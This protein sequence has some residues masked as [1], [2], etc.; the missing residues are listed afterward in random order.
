MRFFAF[1]L[2]L[3][4]FYS[5]GQTP[6]GHFLVINPR[7]HKSLIYD[8]DLDKDKNIVT[9]SFDKNC[10][11]WN[12]N[13]GTIVKEFYGNI[14]PGSEGMIYTVDVSPN[15]KLLAV[16]GWMGK[17]DE[18]ED[19][20][21]IRIFDYQTGKQINRLRYHEDAVKDVQFTNDS[22]YLISGDASGVILK[23]NMA[24]YDAELKYVSGNY[25]FTNI[26]IA[27]DFFCTA[28]G[29][30]MV[31][32]WSYDK[33]KPIKELKVF[34]KVKGIVIESRVKVSPDNSKILVSGKDIGMLLV[35][36]EKF[37]LQQHFFTGDNRIIDFDIT[38]SNQRIAVAIDEGGDNYAQVYELHG[39]KWEPIVKYEHD[40]LVICTRFLNENKVVSV[41]GKANELA[42]WEIK[43]GKADVKRVMKGKGTNYYSAGLND[44][45]LAFSNNA[46]KAYGNATYDEMFDL[47]ERQLVKGFSDFDSFN[48]P[49]RNKEG[50]RLFEYDYLRKSEYDPSQ[51]L[52]IE[53]DGKIKDSI[54]FFP[55]DGY[56]FYAYSF[57]GE[58]YIVAAGSYGILQAY[59]LNGN[60]KSKFVGHEGGLRS[61][62]VSEDGKFLVTSG[63]DM[64]VRFW[65][66][67]EI[68]KMNGTKPNEIKPT[69]SLFIAED[70]EWVL[71]NQ[72]GYFTSSRKGA[73]Y[74]G[75]H[76]NYGR[77]AAAK[78]YPF[79][80]FD[81]KYNRPDVLLKDLE[82]ADAGI[83]E[84]YHS[85]YVKRLD[86][87]GL[88]EDDLSADIHTP[89]I[90]SF[91]A[92]QV[93]EKVELTVKAE[94][95]KFD[96]DRLNVYIN[97]VPLYGRKGIKIEQNINVYEDVLEIDLIAGEN[98]I[99]VSVL[100]DAGVESLRETI[101][102]T[103]SNT[104]KGDVYVV[105]VGVSNY[106]DQNY[107]LN[108]AAKDAQDMV[109]L[110]KS[111]KAY[112]QV[113]S[114]L[115]V[116][117]QVTREKIFELKTFFK[118]AK[119]ND[120]VVM[121]IAGHGVLDVSLDYFF[122]T[123]DMNFTNPSEKGV[124][125]AEL[126]KLFDGIKAIK[127]LLIMDTCHSGEL[128][129][130]EVEEV[131]ID[132]TESTE[133]VVFRSSNATTTVRERQ[134]LKKTNEAVKEMFN[135]LNRGTG[136][137]VISS[138]GGVEYAMESAN[139]KNG[140]F[141]YCMLEGVSSM[142]ADENE[143]G[144]IM[145]S[146]LQKYVAEQVLIKS[147]GKQKPSARFENISLDYQIW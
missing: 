105:G 87:M 40:N 19:L 106:Q 36:D 41:G 24:N 143:D 92:K 133:D 10:M 45:Q 103:N 78:F 72:Q 88:T 80:Q 47:F 52:L 101:Y 21:D 108:Y 64:T 93:G 115:L 51:V 142:K 27:D 90:T 7:G 124:S 34:K 144:K 137:T 132:E 26:A 37:K 32:K 55:W 118:A 139:W 121:F 128:F 61:V 109:D 56:Q 15:N 79:D 97:D 100:N 9:G 74:V 13:K 96:L 20:G 82:I 30:G 86:R 12:P 131:E 49:Q 116:D 17:D 6:R 63:V 83:I 76:V 4:T 120:V 125:Y 126:E 22:K 42:I 46:T 35:M 135:D 33:M 136:T 57:V 91:K 65:K 134:G 94:D 147:N 70:K 58:K 67:S 84:L 77:N 127:K 29:D 16:A 107:N 130:D 122:C 140:L 111:Q 48:Y 23:W 81:L 145:L 117:E 89:E 129:K 3:A 50:L 69:A 112:Q 119:A 114:M 38:T 95:K 43:N 102:I 68:G 138:A 8:I 39:K 28:H 44:N 85:A 62:S 60:I 146:E 110:F 2:L 11:V 14:G 53:K 104:A 141:T 75:Y 18:S 113:H 31:Y 59:D 98:K 1:L 25:G 54:A 99:E 73:K 5:Y 123:Y 71:W 66:I